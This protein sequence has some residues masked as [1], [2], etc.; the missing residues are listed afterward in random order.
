MTCNKTWIRHFLMDRTQQV[1]VEGELSTTAPVTSGVP[2]GTVLGPSLFLLYINDLTED[3]SSVVR[4]FAD[5]TILYR[6]VSTPNDTTALQ[7]D[8]D[9]LADWETKWQMGFNIDKCH[10][11]TVSK[12]HKPIQH[13]YTLHQQPLQRVQSAK[14]LG[15][16]IAHDLRWNQHVQ[17]IASKANKASAFLT[18]N[19]RACSNETKTHCYKALSR[20]LMEYASPIW[21][22][23]QQTLRNTLEA[24]QRRAARRITNNFDPASSASEILTSLNL[25]PL[26]TRRQTDKATFMYKMINGLND[27]LPPQGALIPAQR[28]TRGQ[29]NKLLQPHSRTNAHLHSLFPSGFRLWNALPSEVT[30][31]PSVSAFKSLMGGWAGTD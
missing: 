24:T 19:L 28:S 17:C 30:S 3:I 29:P 18:R 14:Y 4:L 8:L 21:D 12:K 1:L 5:D 31:A 15:I 7:L 22:P 6:T 2:Q 16:E 26:H 23:S 27:W 25:Q 13:Q 11:L 10:I 9:R 20:P